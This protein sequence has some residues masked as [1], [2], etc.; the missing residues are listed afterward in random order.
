MV[1]GVD[2]NGESR[3]AKG[4]EASP[5]FEG[6][7]IFSSWAARTAHTNC[8]PFP[9]LFSSFIW[10][11]WGW[12]N[13][14][15]FLPELRSHRLGQCRAVTSHGFSLPFPPSCLHPGVVGRVGWGGAAFFSSSLCGSQLRKTPSPRGVGR[16]GGGWPPAFPEAGGT[17]GHS[18]GTEGG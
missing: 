17:E 4:S 15:A 6:L 9:V 5:G 3:G 12:E 2:G 8:T 18:A 13:S 16:N 7:S 10:V 11:G 1:R 14:P